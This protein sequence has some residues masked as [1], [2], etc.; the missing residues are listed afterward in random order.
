MVGIQIRFLI[1]IDLLN[2]ANKR[3]WVY[4]EIW[5][6]LRLQLFF[7]PFLYLLLFLLLNFD[8]FIS[9]CVGILIPVLG[10]IISFLM[11]RVE[12]AER[13]INPKVFLRKLFLAQMLKFI[14]VPLI[15]ICLFYVGLFGV[16]WVML[17]AVF[18]YCIQVASC[19]ITTKYTWLIRLDRGKA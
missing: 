7:L 9:V 6:T 17:G 11:V 10:Q 13:N 4:Q 16:E 12:I 18:G 5:A 15:F 3:S 8:R 14:F 2:R 19:F 1:G